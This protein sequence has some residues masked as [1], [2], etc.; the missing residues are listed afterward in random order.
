MEKQIISDLLRDDNERTYM[1][2][3]DY[4]FA[5]EAEAR[6]EHYGDLRDAQ[7]E[8]FDYLIGGYDA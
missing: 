3:N 6:R 8:R 4:D 1:S 5:R 2:W 7:N